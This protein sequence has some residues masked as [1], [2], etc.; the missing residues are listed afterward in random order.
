[1]T[2]L[3][4]AVGVERDG[5]DESADG[6]VT[7]LFAAVGVQVLGSEAEE[8]NL[9]TVLS[10][11]YLQLL[12][13]R[14]WGARRRKRICGRCCYHA[15]FAAVG[16]QL[17]GS[18]TAETN[19]RTLLLP[20]Y[21]QLLGCSWWGARRRR[22]ICGRCCYHAI[23]SCWGG[24][25]RRRRICGRCCYHAIGSCWGAAAGERDGGDESAD[26]A[27]TMLFAAV[28]QLL[29]WRCCGARLRRRICG[30]CC[31]HAYHAICSCWGGGAGERDCGDESADGAVTM[32]FAAVGVE[33]LGRETAETNLRTLLCEGVA[34]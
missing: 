19:L 30:R 12:G 1:M 7:T 17:L 8:T 22:R 14:C 29:G 6:A 32:L 18:E 27:V 16:V 10:P 24:A 34:A 23:C 25:R 21:L 4:A 3:F 11:C 33:V 28:V 26:G 2:M 9:R 13:C 15:I 5:G 20:C 31:Y